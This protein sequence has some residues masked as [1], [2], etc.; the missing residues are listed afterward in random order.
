VK[1]G[2]PSTPLALPIGAS[3][4]THTLPTS[5]ALIAR[6]PAEKAIAF[7]AAPK[8]SAWSK[9]FKYRHPRAFGGT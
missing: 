2:K 8:L 7:P 5:A 4:A 6:T 1:I 9:S 3:E